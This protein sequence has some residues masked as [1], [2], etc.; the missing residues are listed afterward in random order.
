[1]QQKTQTPGG[2]PSGNVDPELLQEAAFNV[3]KQAAGTGTAALAMAAALQARRAERMNQSVKVLQK[4][5]GDKHPDVAAAQSLAQTAGDLKVMISDQSKRVKSFPKLRPHEWIVFGT[6]R[7]QAGKP[8][9]GL[10]VR[11]FDLDRKFDD[12]L[13]ET[14]TDANGD[15]S[16]VYHERDFNESNEKI[17]E[18]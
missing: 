4:T 15:F 14:E 2:K 18:L 11:V 3:M 17:A 6:V 9:E 12:L 5:L 16:A 13:G 10:V 7:D 8:A 1:M